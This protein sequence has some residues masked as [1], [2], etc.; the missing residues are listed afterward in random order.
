M[1]IGITLGYILNAEDYY[2]SLCNSKWSKM[3]DEK[4]YLV[5]LAQDGLL[6]YTPKLLF[7]PVIWMMFLYG[8][9]ITSMMIL[10][11]IVELF[12]ALIRMP[13]CKL[14]IN[15]SIIDILLM[16]IMKYVYILSF[17]HI[18]VN[19]NSI[20]RNIYLKTIKCY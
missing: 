20:R 5:Y 6:I 17:H 11:I 12:V 7:V 15:L 9:S 1:H 13:Y 8:Y 4:A 10:F 3:V 18:I 2:N 14:K 19:K 16:N